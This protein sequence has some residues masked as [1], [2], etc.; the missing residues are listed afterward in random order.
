MDKPTE[1]LTHLRQRYN[2]TQRQV[3]E[4]LGVTEQ[5]VSNWERRQVDP[6]LTYAQWKC[7]CQLLRC[8]FEEL[9]RIIKESEN[10]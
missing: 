8:S 5:T 10:P 4:V 2:L 1:W 9:G 7:L 3:A 6:K